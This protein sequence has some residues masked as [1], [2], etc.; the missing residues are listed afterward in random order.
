MPRD[1]MKSHLRIITAAKEEF[2]L[3]GFEKASMRSIAAAVDMTSAALYRHFKDKETM[4]SAL[5]E[6]VLNELETKFK[7]HEEWDYQLLFQQNIEPMWEEGADLTMFLD[8]IYDNFV[9]FRLLICCSEGTRY[10]DF[11]HDFVVKEQEATERYMA[12]AK[13]MGVPVNDIEPEELHLLLSA[14]VTAMFEVVVHDFTKE[15]AVHYMGTL[16]RF[17]IPGWRAVLGL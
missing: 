3:K 12:E 17:F 10:A 8:L 14:Y 16:R 4:F 11:I 9:E 13:K 15:K 1:K 7:Q 5:V 6:P 2:L